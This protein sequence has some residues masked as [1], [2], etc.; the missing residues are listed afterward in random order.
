MGTGTILLVASLAMAAATAAA[1]AAAAK[2]AADQANT[3]AAAQFALNSA[4]FAR[5]QGEINR[6]A[7]EEKGDVVHKAEVSLGQL[8]ANAGELGV[9]AGSLARLVAEIGAF[10]GSDLSR[11]DQNREADVESL[12]AASRAAGQGATNTIQI[13]NLRAKK[14][15]TDAILGFVGTGLS[16]GTKFSANRSAATAATR[17]TPRVT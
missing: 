13:A 12:Q 14:A 9:S 17:T 3:A 6:V 10:E 11:I 7:H 2:D 1:S 8:T 4:E 5:Q 15:Q 16:L